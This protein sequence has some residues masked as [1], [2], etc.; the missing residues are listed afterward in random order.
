MSLDIDYAQERLDQ[1]D[2]NISNRIA[3]Y[4]SS[5]GSKPEVI[6]FLQERRNQLIDEK[7]KLSGFKQDLGDEVGFNVN[8]DT[9]MVDLAHIIIK[10]G[11][12]AGQKRNRI[13]DDVLSRSE[14]MYEELS[15]NTPYI[16]DQLKTLV[17]KDKVAFI[18]AMKSVSLKYAKA[19]TLVELH[20]ESEDFADN[21]MGFSPEAINQTIIDLEHKGI[22]DG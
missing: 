9:R 4:R 11:D 12:V 2:R 21:L 8:K 22:P 18:K 13:I 7:D 14:A 15:D 16:K 6:E 5:G 17:G 19:V 10:S 1:F 3:E 20:K